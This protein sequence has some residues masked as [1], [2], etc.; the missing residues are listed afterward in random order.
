MKKKTILI[1]LIQSLFFT[2]FAQN[3]P[4]SQNV[5]KKK[6]LIEEFTGIQCSNCPQGHFLI[7]ALEEDYFTN[8]MV[9]INYHAGVFSIPYLGQPDFTTTEGNSIHDWIAPVG[10]PSG[11]VQR[12]SVSGSF[13]TNANDWAL[14]IGNT[15]NENSPV[16]LTIDAD[17]NTTTR[18]VTVKVEIFY[19][20]PFSAGIF[21]YLNVGILQNDY[22]GYQNNPNN[23]NPTATVNGQYIHQHIFRGFINTSGTWGDQIDASQTGV[24][25][26]N[27]TYTLPTS[28]NT[29]PLD[30]Q[31]LSFFA[32]I[33]E[34]HNTPT[35]SNIYTAAQTSP[36][37]NVEASA[38]LIENTDDES[39]LSIF[40]N[41]SKGNFSINYSIENSLDKK[42]AIAIYNA[43]GMKVYFNETNSLNGKLEKEIDLSELEKGVYI[44]TIE[45]NS[46][47]V[48][49]KLL[50]N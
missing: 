5:L 38:G 20:S 23:Y 21:N 13:A 39:H 1:G 4:V 31:N 14:S 12:K 43:L 22:A 48:Q 27:Y 19:T 41:P 32:F 10:Y 28:V 50:I 2:S 37:Y 16:N 49:K 26:K 42:C 47:T 25:T 18:V 7:K 34:G 3:A 45:T 11:T 6:A 9:T 36:T 44:L 17:I 8:K 24:I 29:I 33:G 30:I 40:P 46:K 15:T 35:N